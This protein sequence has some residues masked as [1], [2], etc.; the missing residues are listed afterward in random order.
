MY[1]FKVDDDWFNLRRIAVHPDKDK[2]MDIPVLTATDA[3]ELWPYTKTGRQRTVSHLSVFANK[4]DTTKVTWAS[5]QTARGHI[6]EPYATEDIKIRLGMEVYHWDNMMIQA[7]DKA[8]AFSP[9]AMTMNPGRYEDHGLILLSDLDISPDT[10]TFEIKSYSAQ[11]HM[12]LAQD[13]TEEQLTDEVIQT[14]WPMFVS[15]N[16]AAT[17]LCLYAPQMRDKGYRMFI[18]TWNRQSDVYINTLRP[19]Y[20]DIIDDWTEWYANERPAK[21]LGTERTE[22]N[23]INHMIETGSPHYIETGDGDE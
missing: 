1:R 3:L 16:I 23:V 5:G 22:Q 10:Q 2:E 13:L 8:A 14:C 21:T 4:E 19:I 15:E 18:F 17:H 12:K 9:D 7:H 11:R 6:M 20:Q